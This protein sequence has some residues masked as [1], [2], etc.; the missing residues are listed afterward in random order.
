MKKVAEACGI[1]AAAVCQWQRVPTARLEVVAHVLGVSRER[2]RPDLFE[3][4]KTA[5]ASKVASPVAE[6]A[7][8]AAAA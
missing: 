8:Q 2:L 5:K 4:P 1:S 7:S 3:K 6:P